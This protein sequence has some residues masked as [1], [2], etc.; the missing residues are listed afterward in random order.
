[1]SKLHTPVCKLLGIE[2][3]ILQAGMSRYTTPELVAAVSNAGGLGIIGGLSRTADELREEIGRVREL[4]SR[5]FGVN[6]VV[7]QLDSAAVDVTLE[8]RVP[9]LSLSWGRAG[10]LA[11]RARDAGVKVVHQVNSPEEAGKVAADGADV[12]VAQGTEGGGHV[13]G[14]STLPLVPQVVDIVNAVPVLAAGGI[15]DGRGLA[16]ALM[17]GAQGVLIGTRFLA[18]PEASGR[19]HSKDVILN[20]LGSQTMASKFFDDVLGIRWP[21]ALVRSI[22]NPLLD[23]WAQRQQDW[24]LAAD[25]IRPSLEAA[26]AAGDFV[27][28]GEAAGLIHDIVP[29]GE[30]VTRI[31]R[32]AEALLNG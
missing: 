2:L 9:V 30:L 8:L 26:I 14:M 7:S 15:A 27:L 18:T 12:V 24:T 10:E 23:R 1:M 31:A 25:Q 5:P 13:G 32:E 17:L 4:T 22:R 6:H 16:A 11:R 29:A 28:A 20:A 19:G 3:P 21:G